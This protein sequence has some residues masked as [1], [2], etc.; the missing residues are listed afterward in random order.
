MEK[1]YFDS[2]HTINTFNLMCPKYVINKYVI[3]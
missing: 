3:K 1:N 2:I